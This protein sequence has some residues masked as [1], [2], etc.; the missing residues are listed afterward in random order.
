MTDPKKALFTEHPSTGLKNLIQY[1]QS[2][3]N[4]DLV[5]IGYADAARRLRESYRAQP[6]DDVMLLP[7]MFV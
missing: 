2:Q 3:M 7:F 6:W 4:S 1:N 5:R